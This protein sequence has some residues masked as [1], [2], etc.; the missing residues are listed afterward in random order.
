MADGQNDDV[1]EPIAFFGG[2]KGLYIFIVIYGIVQIVLL[3]IFTA[4]LNQ[5]S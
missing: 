3:Y 4:M 2:W 5:N 1:E